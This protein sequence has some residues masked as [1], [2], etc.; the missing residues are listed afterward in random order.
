MKKRK[1][2]SLNRETLRV[3]KFMGQ[4][5]GGFQT[6]QVNCDPHTDLGQQTDCALC[7]PGPITLGGCHSG[8]GGTACGPTQ[9]CSI[10]PC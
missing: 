4:V 7:G 10:P 3:E 6:A 1:K 2:L 5:V 8:A 9:N